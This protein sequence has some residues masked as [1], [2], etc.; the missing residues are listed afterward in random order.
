MNGKGNKSISVWVH[1]NPRLDVRTQNLR[2][3]IDAIDF[4]PALRDRIDKLMG[5]MDV[6]LNEPLSKDDE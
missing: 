6:D 4:T 1:S 2:S 5:N 3:D